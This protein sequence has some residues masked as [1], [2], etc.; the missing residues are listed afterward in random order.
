MMSFIV[1]GVLLDACVLG[2]LL[3]APA[4]GYELTQNTQTKLGISESAL[5]PV[6]R[7]LLKESFLTSYDEPYDGRNRRYYQL[8]EK[9]IHAL[10]EYEMEWSRYK[11]NIDHFLKGIDDAP[12][13]APSGTP[14]G[15]PSD[16]PSDSQSNLPSDS[17]SGTPPGTP[18][19]TQLDTPLDAQPGTQPGAP[20]S[21]Q[22]NSQP[23]G[24]DKFLGTEN[25][26]EEQERRKKS[27]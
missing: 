3:P 26:N 17:P 20:P 15:A 19:G 25:L 2:A 13:D 22:H 9:G 7:R 8:T 4:Y 21:T 6:L 5:Y 12:S 16:A 23:G 10:F 14:P 1:S 24:Q 18:P 27:E 11:E